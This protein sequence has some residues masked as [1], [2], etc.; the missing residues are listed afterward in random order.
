MMAT[1][2]ISII[3]VV[4]VIDD[5]NPTHAGFIRLDATKTG[6][7]CLIPEQT[8]VGSIVHVCPKSCLF[9]PPSTQ[10]YTHGPID[11]AAG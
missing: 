10:R 2:G 8:K 6:H 4:I 7:P 5:T 1:A 11:F 9:G 3:R